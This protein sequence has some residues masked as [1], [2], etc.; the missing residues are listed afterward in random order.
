[1]A[2][3]S[4]VKGQGLPNDLMERIK[5]D[6]IFDAVHDKLDDMIDPRKFCGRAPEQVDEFLMEEVAPVLEKF[7]NL[8]TIESVDAVNV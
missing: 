1:M 5:K 6:P 3:G 4:V 8:L 7:R 2:A